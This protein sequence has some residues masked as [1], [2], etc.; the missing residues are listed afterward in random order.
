MSKRVES[1]ILIIGAGPVG[2]FTVFEAGLLGLN[3]Q[4]IDNLD[5]V[6]GQCAELYPDKPIFDIPGVPYQTAEEHIGALLEQIKPFKYGLHLN[7]RVQEINQIDSKNEIQKWKVVTSENTEFI[8]TN[9]FI[10]A[11]GG[12]FEPRR[13]PNIIDPDKFLNNGVAYSVKDKSYYQNKNLIIFGGGDSALDWSVELADIADSITL[14]HRRD[15]FRGSPGTEAQMRELV[16][17]GNLELKTPYVIEELLGTNKISGVSIKNFE[18]K[19]IETLDCN[20]ILFLFGLNK[21]LGPLENWN[22]K[23]NGKKISVDT[24]KYQTSIEGIYA[25][26]DINDYPGKLD[27]I[28]CGYHETTLAVQDAYQRCFPGERVPFAYTT[29]NTKLHKKLGIKID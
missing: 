29:S 8:A 13:P 16:E 19:E 11:G 20:E 2:L 10:A 9:V 27:L 18:S 17:T 3:C 14:I 26:G 12:S 25:V 4:I 5:R 7:Q 1:D 23:L 28:L 15:A 24:E 21:K 22:L 6:G